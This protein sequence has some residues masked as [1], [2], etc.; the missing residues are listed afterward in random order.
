MKESTPFQVSISGFHRLQI[1]LWAQ[2]ASQLGILERFVAEWTSKD[3]KLKNQPTRWGDPL[4]DLKHINARI[5]RGLGKLFVV[6]YAVEFDRRVS[7]IKDILPLQDTGLSNP[8]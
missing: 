6:N 4:Y 3:N 5:Y 7:I 2:E 8:R 1:K